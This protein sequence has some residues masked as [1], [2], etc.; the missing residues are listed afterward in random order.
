MTDVGVEMQA[1]AL[2]ISELDG[3]GRLYTLKKEVPVPIG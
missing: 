3:D 2:L 1:H